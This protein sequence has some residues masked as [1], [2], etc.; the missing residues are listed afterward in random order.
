MKKS[1]IFFLL[2]FISCFA[3]KPIDFHAIT[4]VEDL[5]RQVLRDLPFIPGWCSKEK[6]LSFIDLV[7]EVEPQICVEIGVF[8]GS[9]IF[10]VASTL[11]F[12]EQGVVIAID[13]WD[14]IECL[15][16]MD[17]IEDQ[18]H[19]DW[20]GKIDMEEIFKTYSNSIKKFGTENYIITCRTTSEKAAPKIESIDILYIDG[21][22]SRK[23]ALQDVMLYLPKVCSGGYIWINDSTW[24]CMQPA[25]ELLQK[26][27]DIIR[28]IDNGNCILFRK[29]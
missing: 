26:S 25:V 15:K 21:N 23:I 13:P 20:W 16:H 8:A 4:S 9:S 2:C 24:A 17:P 12:L 18:K 19:L 6:A 7:L 5:K 28:V 3:N 29:R 10:P 1:I 14:K 11:K 27:C 22:H